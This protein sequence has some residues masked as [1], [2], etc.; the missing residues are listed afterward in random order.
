MS[1]EPVLQ[2]ELTTTLLSA[3]KNPLTLDRQPEERNLLLVMRV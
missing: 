1:Y 3:F 2:D